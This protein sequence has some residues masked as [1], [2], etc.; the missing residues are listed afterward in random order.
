VSRPAG[1]GHTAE[2][3]H[4]LV[5]DHRHQ[6]PSRFPADHAREAF[7]AANP[8]H[9]MTATV[10]RVSS[11]SETPT[12]AVSF[13]DGTTLLRTLSLTNMGLTGPGRAA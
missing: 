3:R 4:S 12:G 5:T 8:F 2:G 9:P 11:G 10:K 6:I 1:E 13:Y 7:S